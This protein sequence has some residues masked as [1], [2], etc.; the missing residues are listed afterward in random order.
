MNPLIPGSI[1]VN[2]EKTF[3]EYVKQVEKTDPNLAAGLKELYIPSHRIER[4]DKILGK[5]QVLSFFFIC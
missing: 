5:G 1:M 4:V 2:N 3:Q